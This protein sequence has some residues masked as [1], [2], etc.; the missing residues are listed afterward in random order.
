M[1]ACGRRDSKNSQ[2]H[3]QAMNGARQCLHNLE[4]CAPNWIGIAAGH[5]S[6]IPTLEFWIQNRPAVSINIA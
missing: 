6:A 5:E 4:L 3:A 1:H 2:L